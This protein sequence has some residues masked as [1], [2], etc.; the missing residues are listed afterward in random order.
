M[1]SGKYGGEDGNFS[2]PYERKP[3]FTGAHHQIR[4]SQ[5]SSHMKHLQQP[6]IVQEKVRKLVR[7]L[8]FP[9]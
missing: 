4:N 9:K 8:G 3:G 7:N 6:D 2:P 1:Y 5:H